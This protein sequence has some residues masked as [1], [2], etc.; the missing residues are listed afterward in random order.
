M[1]RPRKEPRGAPPVEQLAEMSDADLEAIAVGAPGLV[2]TSDHPAPWYA[3]PK[4]S[5]AA[6]RILIEREERNG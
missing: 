1:P 2:T 6:H 5:G 4:Y 3:S